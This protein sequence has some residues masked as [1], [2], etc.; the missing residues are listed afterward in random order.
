MFRHRMAKG[1]EFANRRRIL[2]IAGGVIKAPSRS[3]AGQR[4][5]RG[6]TR[7]GARFERLQQSLADAAKSR[8]RR[9]I[10]EIDFARVGDAAHR[11][12]S[13]ALDGDQH[14]IVRPRDPGA[15][16]LGRLIREPLRKDRRIAAMIGDAKLR[17]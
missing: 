5:T 11:E 14:I 13:L 17:D 1:A 2:D 7:Q 9:D 16:V 3:G 10:I 12:N 8:V 15:H 6:A 4:A